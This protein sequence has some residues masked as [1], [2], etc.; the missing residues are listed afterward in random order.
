MSRKDDKSNSWMPKSDMTT[1]DEMTFEAHSEILSHTHVR[2]KVRACTTSGRVHG[3]CYFLDAKLW[4]N[5][6]WRLSKTY[7][8]S[9][10]RTSCTTTEQKRSRFVSI[11][12]H[13]CLFLLRQC[14]LLLSVSPLL[15]LPFFWPPFSPLVM[16]F[17]AL[18]IPPCRGLWPWRGSW[19]WWRFCE[20]GL[21]IFA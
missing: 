7:C 5:V 13:K 20:I 2:V 9:E 10:T 18:R 8:N 16:I 21:P 15:I 4:K 14:W 1:N 11:S 6:K 17:P 3:S 19:G 12:W